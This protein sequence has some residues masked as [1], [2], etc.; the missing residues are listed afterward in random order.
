MGNH[1]KEINDLIEGLRK[2]SQ[3]KIDAEIKSIR[4]KVITIVAIIA[5]SFISILLYSNRD[6]NESVIDLQKDI[7]S[8]QKIIR[9]S[10]KEID[11]S[12]RLSTEAQADLKAASTDLRETQKIYEKRISEL[13]KPEIKIYTLTWSN[14][15]GKSQIPDQDTAIDIR[16]VKEISV[17]GNLLNDNQTNRNIELEVLTSALESGNYLHY[18]SQRL[19]TAGTVNF[20]LTQKPGF[21]KLRLHV[22]DGKKANFKGMV[23][24]SY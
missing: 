4:G 8:A 1:D 9:E 12:K 17:E 7:I 5:L 24:V 21:M 23:S 13:K 20:G 22:N 18:H 6:V 10:I 19:E 15:T 2:E 3:T 11:E 14:V 16:Y